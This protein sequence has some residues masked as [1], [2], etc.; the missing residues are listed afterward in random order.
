MGAR[1]LMSVKGFA[2]KIH[3]ILLT[4]RGVNLGCGGF[5]GEGKST[6]TTLLEKEYSKVS[7][8]KWD[9][10]HMTWDRKEMM[11]W[12]DGEGK[13]KKGQLPEYSAILPD[14][15]FHM[16]YRRNW[17]M[18]SQIDAISTFNMCRDRH[19]LVAGNI[20]N[21]WELDTGFT[22]RIMFFVYIPR[23][24]TA[25]VFQQDDNPFIDD[26]WNRRVNSKLFK[27]YGNPY[28]CKN[29]LCEIHFP[30]WDEQE[31]KEYLKIRNQKRLLK[32]N[33]DGDR[34]SPSKLRRQRDGAV[35]VAI[36]EGVKLKVLASEMKLTVAGISD[37]YSRIQEV[38]ET[39][40]NI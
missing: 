37:I 35:Y 28:K 10:S 26:P 22:N 8:T 7:N 27:R 36:E 12:I 14:E 11:K 15:L 2:T 18:T 39:T 23:R 19:L 4:D 13:E 38:K 1:Q 21:F 16:F 40:S 30:D 5:T 34:Y 33:D 32:N 3:K 6:F 29:F 9:F 25:W 31:K 24:G 20:P 17:F